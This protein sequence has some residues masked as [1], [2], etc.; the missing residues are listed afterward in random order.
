MLQLG[1][2]LLI[3]TP[4][5]F[6]GELAVPLYEFA[7]QRGLELIITSF[8]GGYIG[9]I[10]DDKWYDLEKYETKTMNWYGPGNG[11]YFT[12]IIKKLI[13]AIDENNPTD[14]AG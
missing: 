10:T 2:I 8:N 7:R 11:R 13:E 6:S 1:N 14:A 3:G 9:Y 4:C 5:D 12:E